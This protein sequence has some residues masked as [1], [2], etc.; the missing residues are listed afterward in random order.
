MSSE[1]R[2]PL[3]IYKD[4]QTGRYVEISP[5]KAEKDKFDPE[6]ASSAAAR[7]YLWVDK[8][9]KLG[10]VGGEAGR[11]R[12]FRLARGASFSSLVSVRESIEH[13]VVKTIVPEIEETFLKFGY[14]GKPYETPIRLRYPQVEM[15]IGALR[16]DVGV[17]VEFADSRFERF[18][19]GP[20]LALEVH[21]SH[22]T[23]P[24]KIQRLAD[25]NISVLE[26]LVP[27]R[28]P[29]SADFEEIQAFKD[30][31]RAKL[32]REIRGE[33]LHAVNTKDSR[34]NRELAQAVDEVATL[35]A[36]LETAGNRIYNL[37]EAKRRY[38]DQVNEAHAEGKQLREL[39]AKAEARLVE[40]ERE[41]WSA[42]F[43]RKLT[44]RD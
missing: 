42:R 22:A 33:L 24:E 29:E 31:V 12:H 16:V 34:R 20:L 30:S 36:E 13:Y 26:V 40:L 38:F 1:L 7:K 43:W 8:V 5:E 2:F 9:T 4:P 21:R 28:L 11:R 17:I 37:D 10:P 32:K 39:L 44:S 3:A 23:E 6:I 41:P 18:F 25:L 15:M 14:L 35:R 19:K 27:E